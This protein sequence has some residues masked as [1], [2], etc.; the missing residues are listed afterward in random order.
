MKTHLL[1]ASF[2]SLALLPLST[3]MAI[4]E[5]EYTVLRATDAYEIREYAPIVAIETEVESDFEDAGNRAFRRL[6]NYINGEN[7]SKAE[8]AMTAPVTQNAS[9]SDSD[10]ET[11]AM[12]A[13]VTQSERDGKFV[14][15]F[16]LPATYTLDSAPTPNNPQVRLTELPKRQYAVR[17]YSGTW[18]KSNYDANLGELRQALGEDGVSYE[19]TP[20]WSR[21]NPP[22][23]LWFLRR[24]EIW[25]PL[26]KAAN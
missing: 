7:Q 13:P 20:I 18:W 11:I 17:R 24:N 19:D 15:R 23:S 8:I 12:T 4:E 5:P 6:F 1:I 25:L 10:S 3:L 2:V 26:T 14:V 9:E 22:F 16:V 21:Y